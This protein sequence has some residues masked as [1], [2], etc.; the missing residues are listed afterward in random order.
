M[1]RRSKPIGQHGREQGVPWRLISS[2]ANK[3]CGSRRGERGGN[4]FETRCSDR[5]AASFDTAFHLANFSGEKFHRNGIPGGSWINYVSAPGGRDR[6]LSTMTLKIAAG[7]LEILANSVV[8]HLNDRAQTIV[9]TIARQVLRDLG[10]YHFGRAI[11][12]DSCI[13]R[14]SLRDRAPC[15][16]KIQR[17]KLG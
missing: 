12:E 3:D 9:C 7:R 5:F 17:R 13:Q 8:C 4:W 2:A 16:C 14:M 6:R 10:D 15:E 11:P 1:V